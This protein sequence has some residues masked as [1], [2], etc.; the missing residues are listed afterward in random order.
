MRCLFVIS[1]ET[2][3][4]GGQVSRKRDDSADCIDKQRLASYSHIRIINYLK[5]KFDINTD[6]FINTYVMNPE[7]DEL[8]LKIYGPSVIFSNFRKTP[9]SR[10][11]EFYAET[12][13]FV[14]ALDLSSYEFIFF[15][16]IDY[17]IKEY[18]LSRFTKIDDKIRY[19][20]LDYGTLG[21]LHEIVYM[22]KRYFNLINVDIYANFRN[23]HNGADYVSKTVGIQAIDHFINSYHS[24]STKLNWNPIFTNVDRPESLNHECRGQRYINYQKVFVEND[25]E[26]DHLIGT[27]TIEENLKLL[28]EGKINMVFDTPKFFIVGNSHVDQFKS[29]EKISLYPFERI[30]VPGASIRGLFNPNSTTGLNQMI[31]VIDTNPINY[32]LFHLGQVDIEFGYYYKSALANTKLDIPSFINDTVRIYERFLWQR[33]GTPIVIGINPTAIKDTRHIFYVNF[34]DTMCH[35][36]NKIQEVGDFIEERTYESLAHIYNDSVEQRNDALFSMNEALKTMC[37]K[38]R[39]GF[40]DMI[41]IL[42]ENGILA[43]RFQYEHLDHHVKPS[44]ELGKYLSDRLNDIILGKAM[45]SKKH[46]F[47]LQ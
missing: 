20:L 33:K 37:I 15:V 16:R 8:I 2:F 46:S 30:H 34:K 29:F 9:A 32:F 36:N 14:S 19:G 7:C 23:P 21:I 35:A 18:F 24:L 6:I 25:D 1:G 12:N 13:A 44:D 3:R 42:N 4:S 45:Y 28:R 40:I 10:P 31:N 38:N 22:P 41:P 26:Y 43:N 11:E 5:E 27:D 17:Y 47:Y 39:W